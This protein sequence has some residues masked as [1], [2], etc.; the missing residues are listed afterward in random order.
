MPD[1][2]AISDGAQFIEWMKL[3]RAR[4]GNPSLAELNRRSGGFGLPPSTVSEM[5]HK[6]KLPPLDRVQKYVRACGLNDDQVHAWEVAWKRISER[7]KHE[8]LTNAGNHGQERQH[9]GSRR[10]FATS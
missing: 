4:A 10:L 1:P 6:Q 5:L 2:E 7:E 9:R 8:Q 3:L